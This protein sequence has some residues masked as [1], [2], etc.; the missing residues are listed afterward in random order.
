MGFVV[1]SSVRSPVTLYAEP[2]ICSTRVL[3]KEMV[4]YFFTAKKAL[5]RRWA[6]RNILCVSI[7][8]ASTS[9]S[10]QELAGVCARHSSKESEN[11]FNGYFY[12]EFG[13]Y[14]TGARR[15]D[16]EDGAGV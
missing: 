7:L 11:H 16:R 9:A 2:P 5:E 14:T 3:L 8:A 12:I 6:S 4:G 15:T 13:I 10:T 1:P